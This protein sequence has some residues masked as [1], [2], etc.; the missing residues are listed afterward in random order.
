LNI[1]VK[2]FPV[3]D[4]DGEFENCIIEITAPDDKGEPLTTV[5]TAYDYG[6]DGDD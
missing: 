6:D 5:T 2:V 1:N 4:D 3:L